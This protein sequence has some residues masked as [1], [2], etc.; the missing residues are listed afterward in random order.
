MNDSRNAKC[1]RQVPLLGHEGARLAG[2]FGLGSSA[3]SVAL[4]QSNF[5]TYVVRFE[6]HTLT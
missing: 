5:G 2:V 3:T 1:C 4:G 6:V